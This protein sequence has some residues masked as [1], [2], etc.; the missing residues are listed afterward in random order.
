VS[1][2]ELATFD[3]LTELASELAA[4]VTPPALLMEKYGLS[5]AEFDRL[6]AHPDFRSLL[7]KLREQW[8]APENIEIRLQRKSMALLESL[9]PE[10]HRLAVDPTI[11]PNIRI[12]AVSEVGKIVSAQMKAMAPAARAVTSGSSAD[13]QRVIVNIHIGDKP[14][15]IEA[16]K[17]EDRGSDDAD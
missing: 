12:A 1:V 16:E 14:V 8:L 7:T 4:G 6:T 15:V 11:P 17:V 5:E 10:L 13:Q 9:L 2:D 3:T